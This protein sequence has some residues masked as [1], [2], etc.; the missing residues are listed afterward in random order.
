MTNRVGWFCTIPHARNLQQFLNLDSS[1]ILFVFYMMV[2]K[3][4]MERYNKKTDRW[5]KVTEKN[6]SEEILKVYDYMESEMEIRTVIE[7]MKLEKILN[8]KDG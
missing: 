5:E 6:F 3:R 1:L 8:D 7:R 4:K 2:K